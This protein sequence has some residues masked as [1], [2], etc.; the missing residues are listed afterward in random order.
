MQTVDNQGST[1]TDNLPT[2]TQ[3]TEG[4]QA[5]TDTTVE[6][7]GNTQTQTYQPFSSGKE[8]FT[9]D[10]EDLDLD[11]TE[12]KKYVSLGKT[13]YKRMQEAAELKNQTQKAY[14]ELLELANKDPDGLIRALNPN[15]NP[16]LQSPT[17]TSMGTSQRD[18]VTD[19]D[20]RDLELRTVK[21]E[22]S[23]LKTSLERQ[24]IEAELKVIEKELTEASEKYGVLKGNMFAKEYVKQE[25]RKALQTPGMEH[26]TIDDVAFHVAQEMKSMQSA[27]DKAKRESIEQKRKQ[28]PVSVVS[29][30]VESPQKAMSLDEV[31]K[32]AGRM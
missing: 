8:K 20:P 22:L 13:A 1:G 10:G 31:K 27:A 32:L 19:V 29:A 2:Q 24:E 4:N 26:V 18:N 3:G 7:G 12:A 11:W 16:Q 14:K 23:S 25:Y 5:Q 21:E 17:R 9:I 30:G 28:A 6:T 15:Y